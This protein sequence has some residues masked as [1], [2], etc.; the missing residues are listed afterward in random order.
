VSE[1]I[2][3]H[4][5]PRQLIIGVGE[6][7]C[8]GH[9]RILVTQAL[10]SCV[11]LTLWDPMT[12]LGGMAHIMLPTA[13]DSVL[14]GHPE[15]FA[16][17]AVPLLVEQL[18]QRGVPKR[19]LLAKLAGGAAMFGSESGLATI[20]Q[21]NIAEVKAQLRRLGVPVR[22][23]DIGGSHARTIELHLDTGILLVR[24][25]MYGLREI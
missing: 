7:A 17:T 24:S 23:E 18:G 11:G 14:Q 8:G 20:G 15:R 25:Y 2:G 16:S 6:I 1:M 12:R 13:T 22:G 9:P 3:G 4:G 19:R 21:R 5:D 10:G